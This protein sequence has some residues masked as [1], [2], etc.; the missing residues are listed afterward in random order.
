MQDNNIVILQFSC[1]VYEFLAIQ[2]FLFMVDRS[3]VFEL[4]VLSVFRSSELEDVCFGH[5]VSTCW[6]K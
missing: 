3:V 1:P 2:E 5:S 6:S 4:L